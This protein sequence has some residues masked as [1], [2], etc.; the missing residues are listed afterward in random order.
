VAAL[1]QR[2][3]QLASPLF[4]EFIGLV[5]LDIRCRGVIED[6]ID[7]QPQ[8]IGGAQE[9]IAFDLVRPDGEEVE[10][11]I[12]LV[13]GNP[14]GRRQPGDIG[15]PARGTGQLRGGVVKALRRHGEQGDLVRR[16]QAG[17]VHAAADG[18]ANAE[19]FPQTAGRQ[20]DAEFEDGVDVD[21]GNGGLAAGW[22]GIWRHRR[23]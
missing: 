8:Q 3:K 1:A 4:G 19:F 20:H 21:L 9:H 5:D 11:A 6:Q 22:Q 16:G 14:V 23:R 15:Q 13:D 7:I 2:R 12:K 18:L 17:T 10:R